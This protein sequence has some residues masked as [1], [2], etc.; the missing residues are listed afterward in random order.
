MT[1][2]AIISSVKARRDN[3][4]KRSIRKTWDAQSA[5][6]RWAPG[7]S[8]PNPATIASRTLKRKDNQPSISPSWTTVKPSTASPKTPRPKSCARSERSSSSLTWTKN[9]RNWWWRSTWRNTSWT[10]R[11][12]A[13]RRPGRIWRMIYQAWWLLCL[14]VCRRPFRSGLECYPSK[15]E[16]WSCWSTSRRSKDVMM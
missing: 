1:R 2:A 15:T 7:P 5:P 6:V 8:N 11:P 3:P 12:F 13:S 4:Q 14:R 10:M 9:R 16:E